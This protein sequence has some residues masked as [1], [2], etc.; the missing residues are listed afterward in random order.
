MIGRVT[1]S[2]ARRLSSTVFVAVAFGMVALYAAF[3]AAPLVAEDLTGTRTLSGLPGAAAIAGTSAGTALLSALMARRGRRPGLAVG[4]VTGVAG[5]VLALLAIAGGSFVAFVL[6]MLVLG[7]GHGANQ[8][9]R[10]AA[11]DPYP[12]VRRGLV[13]SLVVWPGRSGQW[14]ARTSS[15][16]SGRSLSGSAWPRSRGATSQPRPRSGSPP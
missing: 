16:R 15:T 9:A 2:P 3:T 11:A 4:W 7:V 1:A 13:L 14:S 6:A 5:A 12:L 8:L 10:F